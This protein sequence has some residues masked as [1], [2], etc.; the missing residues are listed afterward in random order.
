MAVDPFTHYFT[1]DT[2][3]AFVTGKVEFNTDKKMTFKMVKISSPFDE[4]TLKLFLV[5]MEY[6]NKLYEKYGKIKRVALIDLEVSEEPIANVVE[7]ELL[8]KTLK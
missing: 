3:D 6:M 1:F 8:D 4:E 5:W 7:E 2:G